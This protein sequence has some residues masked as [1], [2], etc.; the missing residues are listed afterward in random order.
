[1]VRRQ[2]PATGAADPLALERRAGRTPR[3]RRC[4][5]RRAHPRSSSRAS[6]SPGGAPAAAG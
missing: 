3:R 6:A 1:M 2:A 4:T 5:A